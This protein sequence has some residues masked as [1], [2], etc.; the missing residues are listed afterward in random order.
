MSRAT[1]LRVYKTKA[2][3]D[4]ELGNAWGGA[5]ALWEYL[6]KKHFPSSKEK[7]LDTKELSKIDD[8]VDDDSQ[9]LSERVGLFL[10]FDRALIKREH[11]ELCVGPLRELASAITAARDPSYVNHW[12]AIAEWVASVK[13]PKNAL[14]IAMNVTSVVDVW[15][16][17]PKLLRGDSPILSTSD[18]IF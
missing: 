9:P 11:V 18:S 3:W 5:W 15:D 4:L 17:Y 10:T 7:F 12:P 2:R 1:L 14:G 6:Y 13:L 16:D 8:I